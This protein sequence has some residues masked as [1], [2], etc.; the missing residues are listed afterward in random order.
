[1]KAMN[2]TITVSA[3]ATMHSGL[4]FLPRFHL[5]ASKSLPSFSRCQIGMMKHQ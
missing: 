3:M 4:Y 5:P 1:M 2:V